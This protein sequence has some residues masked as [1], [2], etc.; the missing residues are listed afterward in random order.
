ME[1]GSKLG[2]TVGGNVLFMDNKMYAV[3]DNAGGRLQTALQGYA[4]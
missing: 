1:D 2:F 3:P 4:K